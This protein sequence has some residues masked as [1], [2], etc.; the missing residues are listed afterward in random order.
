MVKIQ[1]SFFVEV[2]ELLYFLHHV[3]NSIDY[4][5]Y[6]CLGNAGICEKFKPI[7]KR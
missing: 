4:E 7:L 5:L 6:G 1:R 3:T 2:H